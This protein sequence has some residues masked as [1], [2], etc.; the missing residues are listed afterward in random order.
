MT[1]RMILLLPLIIL[2]LGAWYVVYKVLELL[3]EAGWVFFGWLLGQL[4]SLLE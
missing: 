2:I 3:A 1:I 4:E